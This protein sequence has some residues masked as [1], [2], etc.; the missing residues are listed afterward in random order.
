LTV[1]Q[2]IVVTISHSLG[3]EEAQRRIASGLDR[4]KTE[5]SSIFSTFETVWKANHADVTVVALHQRI[6]AGI[7]VFADVIRLE[8]HLPWYF[9]PLQN[10]IAAA[11]QHQG[12][13]TL[14][15]GRG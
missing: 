7:D 12:E 5:F 14:Q 3:S 11:L 4:A 10:K 8:A 6:T 1:A 13:K 2:P 15:I 9:A